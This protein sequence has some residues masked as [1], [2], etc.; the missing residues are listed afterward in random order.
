MDIPALLSNLFSAPKLVEALFRSRHTQS[1]R[2]S[3]LTEL[4]YANRGEHF[5]LAIEAE[6]PYDLVSGLSRNQKYNAVQWSHLRYEIRLWC[7]SGRD[8]LVDCEYLS[9]FTI[10]NSH[11]TPCKTTLPKATNERECLY[12]ISR[13]AG[14]R[15]NFRSE[16]T[17]KIFA[18]VSINPSRLAISRMP[19]DSEDDF[20][21]S[22]WFYQLLTEHTVYFAPNWE[23]MRMAS[24]PGLSC[25][26]TC[27]G[28]NLPWLALDLKQ[29][30]A[31]SFADWVADVA[32]ALPIKDIEIAEREDDH[33]AYFKLLYH[34]GLQLPS[35][36]LSNGTLRLLT[37]TLIP[38]LRFPPKLLMI[39]EPENGVHPRATETILQSLQTC[40]NTQILIASHSPVVIA[41][42]RPEQ[43][44]CTQINK[45]GAVNIIRGDQH[46]RLVTW[47][48]GIDLGALFA[49]GVLG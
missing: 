28:E 45:H 37:Y 15:S 14:G 44:L 21:L 42:T 18:D 16:T 39:E 26:L 30:D 17:G 27:T 36:A 12:I 23:L 3:S 10:S 38:Y 33:H 49:A 7:P 31:Q 43:L 19:F 1:P 5:F 8:L 35:S 41:Q 29:H 48:G 9:A 11:P 46:P 40:D 47:Q 2:A 25:H 13:S 24:P 22:Q 4:I 20:P 6:I 32:E 34:N